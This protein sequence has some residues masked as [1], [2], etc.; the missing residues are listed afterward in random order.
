MTSW[1][2]QILQVYIIGVLKS[3]TAYKVSFIMEL[4]I[5]SCTAFNVVLFSYHLKLFQS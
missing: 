2:T 1:V 3:V 4:F 5:W